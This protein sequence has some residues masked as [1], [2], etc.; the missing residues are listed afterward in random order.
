MELYVGIDVSKKQLD[1]YIGELEKKEHQ[2]ENT[3]AG[4]EK[5]MEFLKNLQKKEYVIPLVICEATGGYERLLSTM[6]KVVGLPIH[7][8]HPNKVRN[9][10]KATGQFAKTD[11][12]D[13][14]ILSEFAK[15]FK[16]KP[17][18]VSLTPEL[19]KLQALFI[20]RRQLLNDKTRESNR[21]DKH[22]LEKLR[23][24]IE[25][26]IHWIER[27][28][29]DI[30]QLIAEQV[31]MDDVI[32]KSVELFSSVPGIGTL[33]AVALLTE[34]PELGN[35]ED[36]QLATLVGVAPLNQDSGKKIG[37]RYTKGGRNAIRKNLYM[38]AVA[39]I[40]CNPDMKKFYQRL[41]ANGKVAKVAL[42]AVIRKLLMM[43]NSIARRGTPWEN[44]QQ[45]ALL[46]TA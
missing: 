42:I 39:S 28:L 29:K 3:Q 24:S 27:E 41:R 40:R 10:T 7:V 8:A 6:F 34:L 9:F 33:T 13:A 12:I 11:R 19:E 45:G 35:I 36:K 16:P 31:K 18:L 26:H 22:L 14:K 4:I 43:L 44:R 17:D 2:F 21:L 1:V 30:E 25:R 46:S 37:K 5:L 32:K 20:R 23:Q 15:V 38:A